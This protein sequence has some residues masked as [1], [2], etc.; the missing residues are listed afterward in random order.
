M[1]EFRHVVGKL[2]GTPKKKNRQSKKRR[3]GR[4]K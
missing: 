1:R 2:E 3:H 4:R